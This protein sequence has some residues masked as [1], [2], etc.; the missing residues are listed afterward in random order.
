[1]RILYSLALIFIAYTGAASEH[2]ASGFVYEYEEEPPETAA[3]PELN[4]FADV[5]VS[6]RNTGRPILVEFST[7]WC[8][9]CEALEQQV[10]KPLLLHGKYRE[11]IIVKKLNVNTYSSVVGFDGKQYGTDEISRMYNVDL[12]PTLVFFDADGDEVSQRIV[13]ITVL[14][15][16]GDELD[17][18]IEKAL[19][20]DPEA[21]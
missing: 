18:A 4:S 21:L 13:G 7:P 14:E 15:Y 16:L 5:A 1:M 6:A 12:Y 2:A 20:A 10:L 9:Y 11:Q 8:R 3:I 17:K 19:Q